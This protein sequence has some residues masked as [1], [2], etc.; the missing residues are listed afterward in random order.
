MA[1]APVRLQQLLRRFHRRLTIVEGAF[2]DHIVTRAIPL[3]HKDR[4][5]LNGL[6]S[7]T[8]QYW[9]LFC[10]QLVL[11]SALGCR[12]RRGST[13]APSVNPPIWERVSY[14]AVHVANNSRV[15]PGKTQNLLRKEPTWGDVSKLGPIII[16]LAPQNASTLLSTF[17]SVTEGPAHLQIVRNA[18]AHLNHETHREVLG[19]RPFYNPKSVR[20]P[21]DVTVWT[22]PNSQDYAF[23]SWVNDMRLI[24]DLLTDY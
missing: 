8:W 6:I 17:G 11:A 10:R 20:H 21:T 4:M 7:M 1:V 22:E 9:C 14:V 3:V 18:T 16:E 19:L 12:T 15:H 24:S 2:T 23:I 13:L 5:F